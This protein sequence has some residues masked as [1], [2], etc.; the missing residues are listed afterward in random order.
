MVAAGK[1]GIAIEGCLKFLQVGLGDGRDVVA[2]QPI[3]E[4][5]QARPNVWRYFIRVALAMLDFLAMN[6]SI[7]C[8]TVLGALG[9]D[10][11]AVSNALSILS[12]NRSAPA[13][14]R[15]LVG[16]RWSFPRSRHRTH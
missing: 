11:P 4:V 13:H 16:S 14:V 15:D 6:I 7:A 3:T 1:G 10:W 2:R 12:L 5:L 8:S 9:A